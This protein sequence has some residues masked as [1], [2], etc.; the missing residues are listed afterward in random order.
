[1]EMEKKIQTWFFMEIFNQ[2]IFLSNSNGLKNII[3]TQTHN[4]TKL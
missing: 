2:T 1:M 4:F 3:M